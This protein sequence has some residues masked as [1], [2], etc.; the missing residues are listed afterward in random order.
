M[1]VSAKNHENWLMAERVDQVFAM[2][3]K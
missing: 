1:Y 2:T 3:E